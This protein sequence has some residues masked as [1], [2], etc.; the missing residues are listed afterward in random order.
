MIPHLYR[1]RPAEAVLDKYE[2]LARQEIYFSPPEELN[3]PMEGYKD[4]F[5]SGDHIV[6]R[7]LLRHYLL[8]LLQTA[9][10]CL[11]G[12]KFDRADLKTIIFSAYENL[13][14]APVRA[15]YQR[16]CEAF[17]ADPNIPKLVDALASR[18]TSLRRDELSHTLRG[19]QPFAL[20]VLMKQ[21]KREGVP[22]VFPDPNGLQAQT[23]TVARVVGMTPADQELAEATR[24]PAST[25]M[26]RRAQQGLGSGPNDSAPEPFDRYGLWAVRQCI[27]LVRIHLSPPRSRYVP[28]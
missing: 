6:W 1:F 21:L 4:V 15:I 28:A 20:S 9:S 7:N 27:S 18:A 23:A 14:N 11:V 25:R 26:A 8:C 24:S 13:P 10:L 17:F 19:I 16:A 3:D 2:E 22:V 12:S 5:W